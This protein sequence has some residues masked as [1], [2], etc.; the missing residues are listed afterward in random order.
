MLLMLEW[1]TRSRAPDSA[2]RLGASNNSFYGSNDNY[3]NYRAPSWSWASADEGRLFYE[4][5]PP[6]M[7]QHP[8][9]LAA[10]EARLYVQID[11]ARYR[12]SLRSVWTL[13]FQEMRL[14][15]L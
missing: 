3:K 12:P 1:H 15:L 14:T 10:S 7:G 11:Q 6:Y 4:Y 5:L 9:S 2:M 8:S 13:S